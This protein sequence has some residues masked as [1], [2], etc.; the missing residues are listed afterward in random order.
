MAALR[1]RDQRGARRLAAVGPV[2][3]RHP[4][5]PDPLL[6]TARQTHSRVADP[7]GRRPQPAVRRAGRLPPRRCP[8]RRSRWR[9]RPRAWTPHVADFVGA[10]AR[11]RRELATHPRAAGP[12]RGLPARRRRDDLQRAAPRRP[13]VGPAALDRPGPD[14]LHR[15]RPRRRAG[16]TPSPATARHTA[17]TSPA[18]AWACGWP[19]SSATTST[20]P[21]GRR[22]AGAA[23]PGWA[24]VASAQWWPRLAAGPPA[25]I[26]GAPVPHR[27]E[28]HGQGRRLR[29]RG[30]RRHRRRRDARRRRVR[31][32]RRPDRADRRAARAGRQRGSPRSPTTAGSTTR[33][34]ACCC[35]P[36]G[37]ADDQLVRRR[38]QGAG[39]AV[40]VRGAGGR[41]DPAGHPRRAAAR[42]RHR[43][44]RL[45]HPDR[46]RHDG[47]RRRHPDPLRRRRQRVG[48][49]RAQGGPRVRRRSST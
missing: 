2:R 23:D 38:Q 13:P 26:L 40:P 17:T 35:T 24:E 43:H 19:V 25:G 49:Q 22:R 45:L 44:P 42:R 29:P 47:R 39:P 37:S 32:V 20:S 28:Q 15:R 27:W 11:R 31:A 14:R 1:G 9:P 21:R 30:R 7:G 16:T 46:R 5:L 41:A 34:S 8:C 10:A 36:G 12:D 33:R 18:A 4:A 6:E 3:L 48:D